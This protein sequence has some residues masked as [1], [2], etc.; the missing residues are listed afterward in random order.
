MPNEVPVD[1]CQL[2]RE[3]VEVA[4]HVEDR[5]RSADRVVPMVMADL[6]L[7]ESSAVRLIGQ[8]DKNEMAY[9]ALT[10]T[11]LA[12]ADAR[13]RRLC[14]CGLIYSARVAVDSILLSACFDADDRVRRLALEGAVERRSQE[15]RIAA[16]FLASDKCAELALAA[17]RVERGESISYV[18]LESPDTF[19][20]G[21]S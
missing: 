17:A 9:A 13:I 5:R 18:E 14:L 2:A 20:L 6:A 11:A 4:V 15:L 16:A 1:V 10:L 21:H 12:G 19:G 7:C 8:Q 3:F